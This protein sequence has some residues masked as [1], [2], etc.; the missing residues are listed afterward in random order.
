MIIKGL[1]EIDYSSGEEISGFLDYTIHYTLHT[2]IDYT[3][4][5]TFSTQA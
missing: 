4:Q 5:S 1:L 2:T 3:I